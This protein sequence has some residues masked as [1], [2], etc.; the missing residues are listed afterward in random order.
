MA[1][2]MRSF[3]ST[4]SRP[5]EDEAVAVDVFLAVEDPEL[6]PPEGLRFLDERSTSSDPI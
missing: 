4:P 5:L 3:V 6:L 2:L 1:N